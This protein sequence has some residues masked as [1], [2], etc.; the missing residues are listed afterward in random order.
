MPLVERRSSMT[1]TETLI[2]E[3][4]TLSEQQQAEVLAFARFLKIGLSDEHR[5]TMALQKARRTASE[6]G[7]TAKDITAEIEMVSQGH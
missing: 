5:F 6:R 7:I 3:L 4:E 1:I 2:L